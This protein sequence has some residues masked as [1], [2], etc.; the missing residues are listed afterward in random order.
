MPSSKPSRRSRASLLSLV[1]ISVVFGLIGLH[2]TAEAQPR[3]TFFSNTSG[4]AITGPRI[5][6]SDSQNIDVRKAYTDTLSQQVAT[7]ASQPLSMA[8]GDFDGDGYADL[9]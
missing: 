4:P 7:G 9:I 2:K 3:G 5:W 1:A 6:L 8:T